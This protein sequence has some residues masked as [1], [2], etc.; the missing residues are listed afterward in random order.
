MTTAKRKTVPPAVPP[1]LRHG[2]R[3]TQTEFH[4]IYKK[5]PE[6]FKA[7]LIGGIV[8]LASPLRLQHGNPH[9]HLGMVFGIYEFNTPGVQSGDNT[10]VLLGRE[11]EPQPDLF[12]RTLPEHGGQSRTTRDGYVKGA[13]ELIAEV[14]DSSQSVDLRGKLSDYRR[15]GVREYLVL[16]IREQHFRWFDLAA[17]QELAAD[18]DGIIR[19]RTFPGLWI[20]VPALLSKDRRLLVVLEQGLATPAHAAFVQALAAAAGQKKRPAKP[21]RKRSGG[22]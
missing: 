5:M 16:C 14:A 12:L 9:V 4:R 1:E 17:D 6:S 15:Y 21:R 10:T 20:D 7:E 11:G 3:M 8:H 18:D 13:P 2:D 22:A 19:V